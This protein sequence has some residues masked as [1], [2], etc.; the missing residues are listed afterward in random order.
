MAKISSAEEKGKIFFLTSLFT[1]EDH[2][3]DR[4]ALDEQRYILIRRFAAHP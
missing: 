2:V 3:I 4:I 1:R